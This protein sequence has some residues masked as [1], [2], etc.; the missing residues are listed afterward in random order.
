MADLL[1]SK[2][3]LQQ[4]RLHSQVGIHPLQQTVLFLNG[5]HLADQGRIHPAILRPPLVERRVA[6]TVRAA[7]LGQRHTAFGLPQ[8][9]SDLRLSVSAC[10]NSESPH[11][12]CRENAT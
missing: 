11:A 3:F 1:F 7:Q 8:D 4:I 10:I 9:P 12:S 6:Q 2:G 5:I